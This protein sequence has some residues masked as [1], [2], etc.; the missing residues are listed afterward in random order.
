MARDRDGRPGPS[1]SSS[2]NVSRDGPSRAAQ[3]RAADNRG[4][5]SRSTASRLQ[6]RPNTQASRSSTPSRSQTQASRQAASARASARIP[7][8]GPSR[9]DR[10]AQQRAADTRGSSSRSTVSRST[11]QAQRQQAAA[12]R[13]YSGPVPTRPNP[14]AVVRS[15]SAAPPRAAQQQAADNR[16]QTRSAP[17]TRVSERAAIHRA[18]VERANANRQAAAQ[19]VRARERAAVHQAVL[20][21]VNRGIEHATQ[22]AGDQR[23]AIHRAVLANPGVQRAVQSIAGGHA[24]ARQHHAL[25]EVQ[26]RAAHRPAGGSAGSERAAVH[27]AVL[28][29]INPGV[30]HATQSL[31]SANRPS[32][33][34]QQLAA[35]TRGASRPAGG[36]AGDQR[37]AVH[38][39]VLANQ[40]RLRAQEQERDFASARRHHVQQEIQGRAITDRDFGSARQHH[41]LQEEQGQA[42]VREAEGDL[43]T[44]VLDEVFSPILGIMEGAGDLLRDIGFEGYTGPF[45]PGTQDRGAGGGGQDNYG[46]AQQQETVLPVEPIVEEETL[47]PDPLEG[48]IVG[49]EDSIDT[50]LRDVGLD[51]YADINL[52]TGHLGI[53]TPRVLPPFIRR[54]TGNVGVRTSAFGARPGQRHGIRGII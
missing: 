8:R 32:R 30:Q 14:F 42:H 39:Y 5:S 26:G 54:R 45:N 15:R 10:S 50:I 25:Q 44:D 6:G 17:Q 23:A 40:D 7:S 33:T 36:G 27:E 38:Q 18:V 24:S 4:S 19:A 20:A 2:R 41:Q 37:A 53:G 46:T 13:V 47:L 21:Q 49:I 3:Q 22:S 52:A 1:R 43:L 16:G 11:S 51:D 29:R 34:A 28:A 12:R 31:A 48:G 9:P 35:D